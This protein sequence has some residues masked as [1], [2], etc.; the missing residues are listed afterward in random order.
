MATFEQGQ[1]LANRLTEEEMKPLWNAVL[2]SY[3]NANEKINQDLAVLYA[4]APNFTKEQ[5]SN[6][7]MY[8]W[9]IQTNRLEELQ[10]K[11][12]IEYAAASRKAGLATANSSQ[13]AITNTFYR[14]QYTLSW[15]TAA[16]D[17]SFSILDPRIV[18][19]SVFGTAESWIAI[20]TKALEKIYG[21]TA[22]YFPP[23]GSLTDLLAR[24]RTAEIKKIQQTITSGLLRGDSYA[25]M[26]R[27]I[28]E[29][30]GKELAQNGKMSYTGAKASAAK[31]VR[32]E[33]TRNLNAGSNAMLNDAVSQG[34]DAQKQWVATLDLR[35][36]HSHAN[37]DGQKV[38]VSGNFKVNGAS[39]S[40]PGQLDQV[41]ENVSCRCSTIGVV[42]GVSPQVRRGRNP[43]TGENEVFTY[44]DFDTWAKDNGLRRNKS[45][46]LKVVG[47]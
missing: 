30:I 47:E 33:G 16:G 17:L 7:A 14:E 43:V 3:R 38:D 28:K 46:I 27:D 31:I 12:S 23:A 45:G 15:F 21:N 35:T 26:T 6:G 41:G 40:Y 20:R 36:R 42:G 29:I 10:K 32:T 11:I 44:R 18:E 19:A 24:N 4:K 2:Q 37:A 34:V 5:L 8:N 39:G 25:Q 13:L 22:Q 1:E 9:T